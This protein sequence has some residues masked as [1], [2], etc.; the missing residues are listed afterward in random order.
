MYKF[1][2]FKTTSKNILHIPK[3]YNENN[4]HANTNQGIEEIYKKNKI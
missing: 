4:C 3:N 2:L 1:C